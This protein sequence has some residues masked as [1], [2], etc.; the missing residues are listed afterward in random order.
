MTGSYRKERSQKEMQEVL[1][2]SLAGKSD[3]QR[4]KEM[5]KILLNFSYKFSYVGHYSKSRE[6]SPRTEMTPQSSE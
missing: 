5:Q 2:K 1:L 6:P 4:K 3:A